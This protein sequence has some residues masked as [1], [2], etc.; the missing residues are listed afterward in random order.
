MIFRNLSLNIMP[1]ALL[2]KKDR[3]IKHKTYLMTKTLINISM[4]QKDINFLTYIKVNNKKDKKKII[5]KN[6]ILNFNIRK[7]NK[8]NRKN[9]QKVLYLRNL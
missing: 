8:L 3:K 6:K 2:M 1:K 9:R 4:M 7:P 5:H